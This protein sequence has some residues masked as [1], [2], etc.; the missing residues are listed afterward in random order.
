MF[1][2]GGLESSSSGGQDWDLDEIYAEA[3]DLG[4][5]PPKG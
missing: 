4:L 5:K 1:T 2:G 3:E